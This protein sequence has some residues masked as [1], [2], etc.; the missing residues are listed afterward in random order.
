MQSRRSEGQKPARANQPMWATMGDAVRV[1][2]NQRGPDGLLDYEAAAR[3][4]GTTPRHVPRTLGEAAAGR[5]QGRSA[6]P[7]PCG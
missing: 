3:Y 7:L 5:G 2:V 4:L 1:D 6:R